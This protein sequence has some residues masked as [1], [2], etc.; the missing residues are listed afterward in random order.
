MSDREKKILWIGLAIACVMGLWAPWTG[1]ASKT[2]WLISMT[3]ELLPQIRNRIEDR[4]MILV[5]LFL[6]E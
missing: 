2:N 1:T 5:M 3:R 4:G 6:E